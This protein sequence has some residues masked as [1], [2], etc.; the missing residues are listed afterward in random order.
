MRSFR[1]RLERLERFHRPPGE[2][3][4]WFGDSESPPKGW[5]APGAVAIEIVLDD[6]GAQPHP[7][8]IHPP[9]Q[10]PTVDDIQETRP[11]QDPDMVRIVIGGRV[12]E[13]PADHP[14]VAGK[15]RPPHPSGRFWK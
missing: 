13:V 12:T 11:S 14:L 6:E 5:D 15:D 9:G 2:V 8:T 1:A 7:Y 3:F 10:G 4:I